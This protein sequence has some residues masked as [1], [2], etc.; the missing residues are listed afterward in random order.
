MNLFKF[1]LLSC[2]LSVFSNPLDIT[3]PNIKQI[4]PSLPSDINVLK[5]VDDPLNS[6]DPLNSLKSLQPHIHREQNANEFSHVLKSLPNLNV[7]NVP[8]PEVGQSVAK[9]V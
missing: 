8:I 3:L 1:V 4:S 7:P 5:R 9:N 6:F 2:I